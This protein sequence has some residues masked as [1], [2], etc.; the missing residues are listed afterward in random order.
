MK[1]HYVND[2][3]N[4]ICGWYLDDTTICDELIQYHKTTHR[5][6]AGSVGGNLNQNKTSTDAYCDK[7]ESCFQKYDDLLRSVVMKYIDRYPYAGHGMCG[8]ENGSFN[9]QHYKPNEGYLN[10]H[11][12]R[13]DS[14]FPYT[15]RHL[16][17]MTYLND[18][19]DAGETEWLYQQVKIKPE[20]GLTV[21]WP[22]DWTFTHRGITSNTEE[23]YIATGWIDYL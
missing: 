8:L 3:N 17:F 2:L 22:A 15:T 12:E 20:K 13:N 16:V 11:S 19:S 21:I 1:Q 10:W 5:R 4:F 18:V 7:Y 6:T 14:K 9:I 23:K